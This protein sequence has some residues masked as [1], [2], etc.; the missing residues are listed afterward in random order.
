M[1]RSVMT[2][3]VMAA[4]A[5]PTRSALPKRPS[6][7]ETESSCRRSQYQPHE[8]ARLRPS[9]WDSSATGARATESVRWLLTSTICIR[10]RLHALSATYALEG[11]VCIRARRATVD[12]PIRPPGLALPEVEHQLDPLRIRDILGKYARPALPCPG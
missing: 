11:G 9:G 3:S 1:T 7:S 10:A 2:A 8:P 6:P 5:R 4:A 12:I